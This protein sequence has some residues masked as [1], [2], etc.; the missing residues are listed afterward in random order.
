MYQ[1]KAYLIRVIDGDTLV[2]NVDLGFYL[3][4]EMKLRLKNINTPELKSKEHKLASE[5]KSFV[6]EQLKDKGLAIKTYKVEKWGRFLADVYFGPIDYTM[7]ELF[8]KG[9]N[10]NELL[11]ENGY[12]QLY[13]DD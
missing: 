6:E 7:T 10:L 2:V 11:I 3:F 4:Q 1:Y 8:E 13:S 5:A 12:A 9:S